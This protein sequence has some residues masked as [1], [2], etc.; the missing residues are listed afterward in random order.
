M[1]FVKERIESCSTTVFK[2]QHWERIR[3]QVIKDHL[4]E[5]R[6]T[7]TQVQGKWD[8]LKRHYHKEKKLYNVTGDNAGSQ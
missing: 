5:V 3:E 8:K 4:S 7:W 6:Q 2:Q 1:E